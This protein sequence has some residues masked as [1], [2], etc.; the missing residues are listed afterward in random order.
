MEPSNLGYNNS[1]GVK[2]SITDEE[3]DENPMIRLNG[4]DELNGQKEFFKDGI[5]NKST[6]RESF[7]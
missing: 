7:K 2:N 1:S 6:P 4:F 5:S 3:S